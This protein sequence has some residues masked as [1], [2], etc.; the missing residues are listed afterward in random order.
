MILVAA[1]T[2]AV[3]A[4]ALVYSR[5]GHTTPPREETAYDPQSSELVTGFQDQP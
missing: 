4:V 2:L 5:R 1:A 3:G